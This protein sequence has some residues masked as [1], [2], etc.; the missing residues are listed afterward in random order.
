MQTLQLKDIG[1]TYP[2]EDLIFEGGKTS[3]GFRG[4]SDLILKQ[5]RTFILKDKSMS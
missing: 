2:E 5:D 3:K 4:Q 1:I